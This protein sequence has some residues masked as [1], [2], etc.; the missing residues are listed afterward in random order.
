MSHNSRG[1]SQPTLQRQLP[2][3]TQNYMHLPHTHK[4]TS[5]T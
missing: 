5:F 1:Q 4:H 3:F 2:F